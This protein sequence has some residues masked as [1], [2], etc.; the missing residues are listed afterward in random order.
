MWTSK[1]TTSIM[2]MVILLVIAM[3]TITMIWKLYSHAVLN[4]DDIDDVDND[5]ND[6]FHDCNTNDMDSVADRVRYIE[7]VRRKA[8]CQSVRSS[9]NMIK[10]QLR[11]NPPSLYAQ[12]DRVIVRLCDDK[13]NRLLTKRRKLYASVITTR[14]GHF[15]YEV[16]LSEGQRMGEHLVVDVSRITLGTRAQEKI[17]QHQAREGTGTGLQTAAYFSQM[18]SRYNIITSDS[19]FDSLIETAAQCDLEVK[20]NNAGGGNCM[21]ISLEQ[22]QKNGIFISHSEIRRRIVAYLARNHQIQSGNGDI[23]RLLGTTI[24][25]TCPYDMKIPFFCSCCS[26][27]SC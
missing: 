23:V 4:G 6:S 2:V 21:F 15:R 18:N 22:L 5:D 27:C 16:Q 3:V 1:M 14:K 17:K 8:G 24:F 7:A 25:S 26:P 12:G 9:K 13:K 20:S 10:Q 19:S 11:S